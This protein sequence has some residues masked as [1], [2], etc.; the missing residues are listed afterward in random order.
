MSLLVSVAE[1]YTGNAGLTERQVASPVWQ[2]QT[3]GPAAKARQ[4]PYFAIAALRRRANLPLRIGLHECRMLITRGH[5]PV[6][7]RCIG[8]LDL[9]H[10]RHR[11]NARETNIRHGGFIAMTESPCFRRARQTLFRSRVSCTCRP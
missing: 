9:E 11:D 5:D 10:T 7:S 2:I 6:D 8:N 1:A 4:S 3:A